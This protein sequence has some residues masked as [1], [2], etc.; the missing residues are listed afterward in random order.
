MKRLLALALLLLAACT[1]NDNGTSRAGTLTLTLT[2]G[3]SSDG[4][5][6]VIVSGGPVTSVSAPAGYQ[7]ASNADGEGTHVLIVGSVTTGVVATLA[8]PDVSR[9]SAYV[10]TVTQAADRTT[11]GLLDVARYHI[12]VAP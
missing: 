5:L 6:V 11:F 8:V 3:G 10:A 1:A 9:A 7:I 2:S 4:A 12:T